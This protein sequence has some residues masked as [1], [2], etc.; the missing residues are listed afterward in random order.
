MNFAFMLEVFVFVLDVLVFKQSFWISLAFWS[1]VFYILIQTIQCIFLFKYRPHLTKKIEDWPKISIWVAARNEEQNIA[2]CLNALVELDYPKNKVQ[3]L[4]G[5]DQSTDLTPEIIDQ[6]CAIHSNIRRIDII[7]D[8]SGLKAKAR[9]MAQMDQFA[10]GEFYLITDADVCVNPNW[11]KTMILTMEH[12][13][14]V[15]SGTTMVK[16]SGMDGWLQE[17]DWAYF[18]GLLNTISYAGIPATAVGN[19]MIV[20]KSAYWETGGYANIRFSITEDYK[21]YSEICNKGWLWNNVMHPG[22]LAYSEKT[23]GWMNLLH[24]RKRWL[25]GGKELPFYWWILFAIYGTFYF[26]IPALLLNAISNPGVLKYVLLLWGC[27]F[28]LQSIQIQQIYRKIGQK[29]PNLLKLI[30]YELYL[31]AVTIGTG[32]FFLLPVKTNWKGRLYK[33]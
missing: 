19:N 15:S 26:W 11:A 18:M 33:V 28:V 12:N 27:K 2:A 9:V 3:I 21:L 20:R 25:S 16:S 1:I 32:I 8:L 22:V 4:V 24:Q 30:S 17:I 6:F 7:D 31:F 5:N 29:S 13:T 10:S 23:S 14:G